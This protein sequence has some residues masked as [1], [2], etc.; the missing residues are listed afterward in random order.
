MFTPSVRIELIESGRLLLVLEYLCS[1]NHVV[2]GCFIDSLQALL[3]R[4][5]FRPNRLDDSFISGGVDLMF[6]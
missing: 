6:I 1:L 4:V 5:K 2:S 3:T